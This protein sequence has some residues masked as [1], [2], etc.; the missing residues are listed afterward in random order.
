M[1]SLDV[2]KIALQLYDFFKSM[3]KVSSIIKVSP[4]SI[5]RWCKSIAPKRKCS[6]CTKVTD[7]LRS[8]ILLNVS[9]NPLLSC[10]DLS[11]LI[12][13]TFKLQ[14]SRQ[15]IYLILRKDGFTYKKIRTRGVS[16]K[17]EELTTIFIEKY[18]ACY[19][20]QNIVSIDESGFDQRGHRTYGYAMKGKQAIVSHGLCTKHIRHNLLLAI[21][22]TGEKF[23]RLTSEMVNGSMFSDFIKS[24]PFPKNTTIMLDNASIHRTKEFREAIESK[25]YSVIYT[26]PYSPEFNPIELVFGS[27]KNKFYKARL[28]EDIFDTKKTV[29]SIISNDDSTLIL[30]CFK[31]VENNYVLNHSSNSKKL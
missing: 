11:R 13:T 14:I 15:L 5:C 8:F 18:R 20:N 21:S 9:K 2:R 26:P 3:R 12:F 27:Y 7:A 10:V 28:V 1:Y 6:S 17:K 4:A 16:K 22:Q 24:L 29:E 31:H 23:Y 25:G 19:R 30:N